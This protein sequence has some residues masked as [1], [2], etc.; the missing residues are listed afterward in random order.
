MKKLLSFLVAS[1]CLMAM[2][3]CGI[4]SQMTIN[5]NQ[6]QTQ[7]VLSQNNYEVIGSVS[8]SQS[9]SYVLGIGGLSKKALES[10]AM[11]EMYENAH[12]TGSQA[13]VN[14]SVSTSV[15]EYLVFTRVTVF[16]RGTIVEFK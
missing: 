15:E 4:S 7:V 8:A 16:A 1:I 11:A 2:T 6:N 5:E 12:L 3:S 9:A 14:P 13:I 10:N